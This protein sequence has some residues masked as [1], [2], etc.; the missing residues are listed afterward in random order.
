MGRTKATDGRKGAMRRVD[1]LARKAGILKANEITKDDIC[2][3]HV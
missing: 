1:E 2:G 3:L